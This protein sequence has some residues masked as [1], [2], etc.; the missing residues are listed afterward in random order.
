MR[1][2]LFVLAALMLTLTGCANR[3]L[4][5][6]Q[7]TAGDWYSVGY[8]DGQSGADVSRVLTHQDACGRHGIVPDSERYRDGWAEGIA[9]FCQP[10]QGFDQGISGRPYRN[11]CP[12]PQAQPFRVAYDDGREIFEARQDVAQLEQRINQHE[13]RIENIGQALIDQASAQIDPTLTP[14]ERID[15]VANVKSLLDERDRLQNELPDL[16]D[17]LD[18]AR[19]H[20]QY[21]DNSYAAS[22]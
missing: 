22:R 8:R 1:L 13:R 12:A 7:C 4:S 10:E 15:L 19:A 5:A 18:L 17:D 3:S 6:H 14:K 21:V 11:V 16:E 9:R 2:Y 20:L